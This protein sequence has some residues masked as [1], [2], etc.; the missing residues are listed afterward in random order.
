MRLFLPAT[1]LFGCVLLASAA[2]YEV[3]APLGTDTADAAPDGLYAPPLPKIAPFVAPPMALYS[4]ID[5]HPLFAADRK[6][7]AEDGLGAKPTADVSDFSVVGI[8]IG[9]ARAIALLKSRSDGATTSVAVGDLVGGWRV[10]RIAPTAV[11]LRSNGSESVLGLSAPS[12]APPS[13]ALPAL[14]S[15]PAAPT[16]TAPAPATPPPA[17][18]APAM[19]APTVASAKPPAATPPP[20]RP[21]ILGSA[22]HPAPHKTDPTISP[23]AGGV[24]YDPQT[25]EPTL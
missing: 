14:A 18:T 16:E 21:P 24:T 3:A 22:Q 8:L 15:E 4:D 9:G 25:G 17:A 12:N 1:L 2:I 5:A 20:A 7:L 10:A 13:Q 19:A 6:P 23:N 11:T